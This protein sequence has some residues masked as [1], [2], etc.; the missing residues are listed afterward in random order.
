MACVVLRQHVLQSKK[1]VQWGH[2]T[3][4]FPDVSQSQI[5]QPFDPSVPL[6]DMKLIKHL[7]EHDSV[8]VTGGCNVGND[9][10]VLLLVL[11]DR[12]AFAFIEDPKVKIL[13]VLYKHPSTMAD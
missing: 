3:D 6:G 4:S 7:K 10:M 13:L 12:E 1:G 2:S 8:F 5:L 11:Y 9:G